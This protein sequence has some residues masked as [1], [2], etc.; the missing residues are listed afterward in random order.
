MA[1]DSWLSCCPDTL[2]ENIPGPAG[3]P[4]VNGNN[5]VDGENGWTALTVPFTM[6]ASLASDTAFVL[7]SGFMAAGQK[8]F[9][10]I[11]SS[12]I[13]GTF[14]VITK[15]TQTSVILK[16]VAAAANYSENSPPGSVFP[17]ATA[18]SPS[19]LQGP[20][21]AVVGG[22]LL[23]LNN[24]ND[25][26]NAV[27]S[28]SNLGLIIGI[29]I[30]AYS[31]SLK[32]LALLPT[33]PDRIAYSTA[34]NIWAETVFTAFART[35]SA[36][37]DAATARTVLGLGTLAVQNSSAI[38]I[39]GGNISVGALTASSD[40]RLSGPIYTTPSA[41]QIFP[42][43]AGTI[44]PN[45]GKVRVQTT[46]GNLVLISTPTIS[47]PAFDGQL[48]LVMGNHA[49]NTVTVQDN[50]TLG[51]STLELGAATR[52]LG[53]GDHLLLSADVT[54]GKWFEVAF[55]NI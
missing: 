7:N 4:G 20:T 49:T 32:S 17:V 46:G 43:S 45:A 44:L 39:S 8:V 48:L 27:T 38:N 40:T 50:D 3:T 15:P 33:L 41:P 34:M 11:D 28:R 31:A 5:G 13:K 54:Q 19:G 51:G 10:G 22:A 55:S 6:P 29:T 35:L 14:E 9:L 18:L 30:Q 12:A 16:N 53:L 2:V 42:N 36:A 47:A 26:A 23:A 37:V 24:L 21:G 1:T 52:L 25:V